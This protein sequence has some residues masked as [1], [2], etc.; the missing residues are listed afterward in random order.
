M[1]ASISRCSNN[2]NG[3]AVVYSGRFVSI[4][5][6]SGKNRERGFIYGYWC[7]HIFAFILFIIIG[8][9][10]LGSS[11]AL[12]L[13]VPGTSSTGSYVVRWSGLPSSN[14]WEE[15]SLKVYEKKQG[16]SYTSIRSSNNASG[17]VSRNKT[18]NGTWVYYIRSC[19]K[20]K[21]PNTGSTT[22]ETCGDTP[23]QSIVVTF[24]KPSITASLSSGTINEGQSSTFSWSSSNSNSCSATGVSGVSAT[25]GSTIYAA[26]TEV[27]SNYTVTIQLTCSGNGGSTTTSRNLTVR[28]VN[29]AP[30]V[31]DISNQ[32]VNEDTTLSDIVF[33][34][35]DSD[36]PNLS[37][38]INSLNTNIIANS[39]ISYTVSAGTGHIRITPKLNAHGTATIEVKVGDGSLDV[40]DRFDVNVKS[41]NDKPVFS[42]PDEVVTTEDIPITFGYNVVDPDSTLELLTANNS[43]EL[44][45][46]ISYGNSGDT[47]TITLT[48]VANHSG[49]GSITLTA[50]D[51]DYL[52]SKT[53]QLSVTSVNDAPVLGSISNRGISFN[54]STG[55]IPLNITDFDPSSFSFW[56]VVAAADQY[57][58]SASGIAFNSS[59]RTLR[60]TPNANV[61]GSAN[62]T[63]F[64]SDGELEDSKSF[65]LTVADAIPPVVV[66]TPEVV[67]IKEDDPPL[68]IDFTVVDPDSETLEISAATNN[69]SLVDVSA[70]IDVGTDSQKR[71]TITPRADQNG[72]ALVS[73]TARDETLTTVEEF[74]IYVAAVNDLPVFEPISDVSIKEDETTSLSVIVDDIETTPTLTATSQNTALLPQAGVVV[75]G[76]TLSLF[77][78][79][80]A[81]GNA[82]VVVAANDGTDIVETSFVLTVTS[83]NDPP[84]I[85]A[86][87]N[88]T[89]DQNSVAGPIS[90]TVS[91]I[92]T[93]TLTLS[94]SSDNQLVVPDSSIQLDGN[95]SNRSITVTPQKYKSGVVEIRVALSDGIDSVTRSFNLTITEPPPGGQVLLGYTYDAL[96]R[97]T[98][99]AKD[100]ATKSGYCYDPAGNRDVAKQNEGGGTSCENRSI[101]FVPDPPTGLS[102]GSHAGAGYTLMWDNS[103]MVSIYK[104]W[105]GTQVYAEVDG[106]EDMYFTPSNTLDQLPCKIS[107]CGASGSCSAQVEFDI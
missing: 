95:G 99:V 88:V 96:G 44:I 63:V 22:Y 16:G 39:G 97:L 36:S 106:S 64:V 2:K 45:Q 76:S 55:D 15:H 81:Y 82:T 42:G 87:S 1:N 17:S 21:D 47:K 12:T 41:V 102:A 98:I 101:S 18:S 72:Q 10:S 66:G 84:I 78:A 58:V 74:M 107:A 11:A 26:P 57:L 70:I 51:E 43:P 20:Y 33:Y 28:A 52:V 100:G 27:Y 29:D 104:I 61:S 83:V 92:E 8:F 4:N 23:V 79:E 38:S 46:A 59:A 24:P 94:A 25:S 93:N 50:Q 54:S 71:L 91:D 90:F 69:N 53:I 34:Y 86:I 67:N 13:N 56:A 9:I 73:I 6:I 3:D 89:I 48:P 49:V 65:I 68:I 85:S 37:F 14:A 62:I 75:N 105:C 7:K 60:I 77:P 35:S 5:A 40:V 30:T 19:T 32:T 103:E 80:N 31:S